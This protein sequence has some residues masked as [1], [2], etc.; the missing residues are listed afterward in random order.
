MKKLTYYVASLLTSFQA[1]IISSKSIVILSEAFEQF[2]N[3]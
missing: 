1:W 3:N 2:F